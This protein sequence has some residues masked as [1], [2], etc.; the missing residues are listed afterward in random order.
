MDTLSDEEEPTFKGLLVR[1]QISF[2]QQVKNNSLFQNN[3][4][5][6]KLRG[7]LLQQHP[8]LSDLFRRVGE[9][10]AVADFK[11][12]RKFADNCEYVY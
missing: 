11:K 5:S 6:A 2:L 7:G 3:E 12:N 9:V 1:G 10:K 4:N 8:K